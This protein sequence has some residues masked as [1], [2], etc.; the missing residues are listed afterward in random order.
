MP[1]DNWPEQE[2]LIERSGIYSFRSDAAITLGNVVKAGDAD[3]DVAVGTLEATTC[4]GVA[5]ETVSAVNKQLSVDLCGS[6]H[7]VKVVAAGA[8][9]R[10]ARVYAAANG[11]VNSG[12]VTPAI[13]DE[14][15]VL[16]YTLQAA[17]TDGDEILIVLG[18]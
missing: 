1:T 8:I 12:P 3:L 5:L 10:G 2:G 11:K 9:S 15:K 16:G 7:I 4:V 14:K 13:G 6:G 18:I 17:T